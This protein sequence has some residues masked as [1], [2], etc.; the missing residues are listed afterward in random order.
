M[1]V[2]EQ[3]RGGR[4][5]EGHGGAERDYFLPVDPGSEALRKSGRCR[6]DVG[7]EGDVMSLPDLGSFAEA[8]LPQTHRRVSRR[9]DAEEGGDFVWLGSVSPDGT[10]GQSFVDLDMQWHSV[11]VTKYGHC[12]EEGESSL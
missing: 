12:V 7:Q 9:T 1:Q 3:S 11:V 4:R 6:E 2:R 10:V 8:H 5:Q